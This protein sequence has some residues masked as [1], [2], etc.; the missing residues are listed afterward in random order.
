M[1]EP[2]VP[3][4][5]LTSDIVLCGA[6]A[7]RK[8][9]EALSDSN[10]DLIPQPLVLTVSLVDSGSSSDPLDALVRNLDMLR[11]RLDPDREVRAVWTRI[12]SGKSLS[13]MNDLVDALW[14]RFPFRPLSPRSMRCMIQGDCAPSDRALLKATGFELDPSDS[15]A[16]PDSSSGDLLGIGPGANSTIGG[17]HF[18]VDGDW[19]SYRAAIDAG[20]FPVNRAQRRAFPQRR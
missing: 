5:S 18:F 10:A 9:E 11:R 8:F 3:T 12:A 19:I 6:R 20:V 16:E 1:K 7:R 17:W 2:T 13:L 14:R 15:Q 4:A